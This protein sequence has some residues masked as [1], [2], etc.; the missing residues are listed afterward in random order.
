MLR[1]VQRRRSAA[2][3]DE[4]IHRDTLQRV[5]GTTGSAAEEHGGIIAKSQGKWQVVQKGDADSPLTF[6]A[7]ETIIGEQRSS[8][9]VRQHPG[10][11]HISK[12]G[13]RVQLQLPCLRLQALGEGKTR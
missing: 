5:N 2:A 3:W 1:W 7:A 6:P 12:N 8:W 11:P 13:I 10:F 4:K 9:D